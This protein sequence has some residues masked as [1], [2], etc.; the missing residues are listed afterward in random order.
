MDIWRL[1]IP[2]KSLFHF[3]V[4]KKRA[5]PTWGCLIVLSLSTTAVYGAERDIVILPLNH[6]LPEQVLPTVQAFLPE[7]ATVTPYNNQLILKVTPSEK[8]SIE[9]LLRQ[10]DKPARQ[11]LISVRQPHS[12]GVS[13]NEISV[14]GTSAKWRI[15]TGSSHQPAQV[16]IRN[17]S[18]Q[19]HKQVQQSV[20]ATEGKP[21]YITTGESVPVTTYMR[22]GTDTRELATEY[23]QADQGFYVTARVTGST[24]VLDITRVND[25]H[26][27]NNSIVTSR[28]ATQVRGQI[29][30]WITIANT[31][32]SSTT[33]QS[34][35]VVRSSDASRGS[36]VIQLLVEE[37]N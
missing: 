20:R 5:L 13:Q 34:G 19:S 8:E 14:S 21:A 22:S 36:G 17:S 9:E 11:L 10:I 18:S 26:Q 23:K 12:L 16:I 35:L 24:V 32:G 7:G 1:C 29:G 25:R 3:F 6:A 2:W 27:Q 31:D 37:L 28:L 33:S 4:M 30:E 15:Q